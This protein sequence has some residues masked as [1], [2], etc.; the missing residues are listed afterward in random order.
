MRRLSQINKHKRN[1]TEGGSGFKVTQPTNVDNG[2]IRLNANDHTIFNDIEGMRI[3]IT[4][5]RCRTVCIYYRICAVTGD[6]TVAK[7][8]SQPRMD[9][10]FPEL[11]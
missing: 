11:I 6:T 9:P 2:T 7:E 5:Q 10:L 4:L 8:S 3:I 1:G